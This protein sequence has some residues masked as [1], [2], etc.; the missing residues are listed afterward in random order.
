[1]ASKATTATDTAV[2]AVPFFTQAESFER[3]WPRLSA[4]LDEICE[5]GVYSNGPKTAELEAALGRYTGA[6]HAIAVGNGTDALVLLLRAAGI[7]PGDEVIVPAFSFFA[8]A[9]SVALVGAVPVFADIDPLTY[10]LDPAGL[11]ALITPRTKAIM[12]VHL[13]CQPADMAAVAE[14]AERHGLL[15]LEDSAEGIGMRLG[16]RHTGLLGAGGVLSF[17][18]TKTLGALGDA[19]MVLT[20]DDQLADT[21]RRLRD[22]GRPAAARAAAPP[23]PRPDPVGRAERALQGELVGTNSKMDEIQAATLLTKLTTLDEDIRRRALLADAY[24]RRL[25]GIP[26]VRRLPSVVQHEAEVDPV[27]YVYLIEADRR[28]ALVA[29][30]TA[31]GIGT[32]TYYP[33]PLHRQPCFAH[34]GHQQGDFPRAEAASH[35]TVALPLYPELT[36]TQLGGVCEAI[37][38]FFTGSTS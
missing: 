6:R 20:D 8:S 31:A 35:R 18:P 28:D 33:L 17:F 22:H 32:E 36:L 37:R 10:A 23:G 16:G 12:P 4:H 2:D 13:F 26:G 24:S 3:Q 21:V 5:S 29:H 19:G 9:S 1:M 38:S 11:E 7:G 30:L 34:L 27:F 14:V 25:R 15:V